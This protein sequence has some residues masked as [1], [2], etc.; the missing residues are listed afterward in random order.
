MSLAERLLD[1]A[2]E[3]LLDIAPAIR[4]LDS[5]PSV[6]YLPDPALIESVVVQVVIP[7][8]TSII[9]GII[10][11]WATTASSEV[12]HERELD[13]IKTL[14]EAIQREGLKPGDVEAFSKAV[15][16][17]ASLSREVDEQC[18]GD[19]SVAKREIA[20]TLEAHHVGKKV[21]TEKA[22]AIVQDVVDAIRDEDGSERG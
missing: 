2:H 3:N 13:E 11:Y 18:Y 9:G 19:M 15:Q 16:A 8:L 7:V 1:K 10:T 5:A 12:R 21:A 17:V 4:P 14:L 22:E 20:G 6:R